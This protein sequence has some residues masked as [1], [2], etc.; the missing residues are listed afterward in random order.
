M[1]GFRAINRYFRDAIHGVFRNF[2]LSLASIS[3]ITITLI[4]VA[5]SLILSY[6]VENF[7][8]SIR[9]DVTV[10]VFLKGDTTSEE[11]N[12]IKGEL[13]T[14]EN[15]EKS[16]IIFKS[17]VE[18]ANEL[19]NEDDTFSTTVDGWTEETNPLLDS[20]MFKVKEIEKIDDTVKDVKKLTLAKDKINNIN[21]G[22][23]MVHQ[24]IVVFN[25]VE[26]V[27]IVAVVA[28]ILV[29]AF[30][31]ANTIK[32]A[33]YSRK[34]EIEI[35]RLV[36]AS[37]VSIKIPFILEGLFIGILGSAI[38]ILITIFG[39]T[40]L[41]D[42]FNGRLFNSALATLV[43]PVPFV[44]YSSGMLLLIGIIVGMIGSYQAVR[45]YLKI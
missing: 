25:A 37:N 32:L 4:V 13:E 7:S 30:L 9:K 22:K 17:K 33:I 29:T 10:V 27:C 24:L 15:I 44:Y 45:K 40:S 42:F 39:Y 2:S 12:A 6:N 35:M 23:D 19:K 31:I 14:I 38:P 20:Y 18:S 16:S 3:C 1:K 41:Y 21:Y 28:L 26:K 34:R 36:G 5:I 11:V 43:E 8:D